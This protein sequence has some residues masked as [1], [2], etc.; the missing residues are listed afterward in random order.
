MNI[1]VGIEE[2]EYS[3]A[4][5]GEARVRSCRCYLISK[6]EPNVKKISGPLSQI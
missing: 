1:C 2:N 6:V 5:S 4:I 3:N